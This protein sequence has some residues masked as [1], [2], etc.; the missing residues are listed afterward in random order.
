MELPLENWWTVA[1]S[2]DFESLINFCNTNK[3]FNSICND[4]RFWVEKNI[5]RLS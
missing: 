2:L 1:L 5:A 3:L 4:E